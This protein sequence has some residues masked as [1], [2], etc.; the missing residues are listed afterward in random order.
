MINMGENTE[1]KL[2]EAK[3]VLERAANVESEHKQV[4]CTLWSIRY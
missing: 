2:E 4:V 3:V 1:S